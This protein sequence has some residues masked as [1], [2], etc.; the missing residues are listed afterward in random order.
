MGLKTQ[1]AKAANVV[2]R[3]LRMEMRK[4][5]PYDLTNLTMAGALARARDHGLEIATAIDVGA[6]DGSW[7]KMLLDIF[8]DINVLAFEPLEER[9]AAL[10]AMHAK[11][12]RFGHVGA[13]AGAE[14]GEIA[15]HVSDDLDS[16]GVGEG[17]GGK[18]GRTVPVR[19][20]DDE[21][22]AR[23]LPGPYLVKLDTHGFEVPIFEGAVQTLSNASL[24]IVEVYTY[25]LNPTSL[26]FP[27]LCQYLEDRGF[28][29]YDM[30]DPMLRTRDR[31][32]WQMDLFFAR[33]DAPFFAS[34]TYS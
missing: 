13:V 3:P 12:P 17:S 20:I 29:P 19:S 11:Y 8:P 6:S 14:A 30:A 34:S 28:R 15:F 21:I 7:S 5:T 25:Q 26:R 1:F 23:N 22:A 31:T 24:L 33:E 10:E 2:L 18:S 32:L 27:G 9:Q 16:S 4:K